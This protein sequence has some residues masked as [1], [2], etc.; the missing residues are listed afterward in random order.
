MGCRN[1][2]SALTKP[3]SPSKYTGHQPL[4]QPF[5]QYD[6]P[7]LVPEGMVPIGL[8]RELGPLRNVTTPAVTTGV[9]A[10]FKEGP[11]EVAGI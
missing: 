4:C 7:T 11:K 1:K 6:D 2:E 10:W 8:K 9:I 3:V 5:A